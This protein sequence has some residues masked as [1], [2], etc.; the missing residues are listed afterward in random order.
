MWELL[1]TLGNFGRNIS[2]WEPHYK[3]YSS[4]ICWGDSQNL[5]VM[6]AAGRIPKFGN[7]GSCW[8]APKILHLYQLL[9][10][11]P[12]FGSNTSCWKMCLDL[13]NVPGIGKS[14][15]FP[16]NIYL[17]GLTQGSP[18]D[19]IYT[20]E[21]ENRERLTIPKHSRKKVLDFLSPA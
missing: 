10:T 6:G 18:H 5:E 8:N 1:P 21:R 3:I 20:G 11:E 12:G 16:K 2:C 4:S 17:T 7:D 15:Y 9:E 19:I 14:H 13:E